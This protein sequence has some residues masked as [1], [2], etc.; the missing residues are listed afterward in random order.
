MA[1]I[2]NCPAYYG[3]KR[4][5]SEWFLRQWIKTICDETSKRIFNKGSK[6]CCVSDAMKNTDD[7][8]LEG[9]HTW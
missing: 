4:Q 9:H 5:P 2:W 6:K 7:V 1:A 8:M 3:N